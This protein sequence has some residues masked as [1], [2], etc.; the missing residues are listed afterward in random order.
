MSECGFRMCFSL[1]DPPRLAEML[2][3]D[4]YSTSDE[5]DE[6]DYDDDDDD[7]DDD[8]YD[9]DDDDEERDE[10][11]DDDEDDEDDDDD[12]EKEL[13]TEQLLDGAG[14]YYSGKPILNFAALLWLGLEYY[15]YN[16][17]DENI[18]NE[19]NENGNG[20]GNTENKK[21]ESSSS[22]STSMMNDLTPEDLLDRVGNYAS[23]PEAI[24]ATIALFMLWK[25]SKLSS[26]SSLSPSSF[27]NYK[28]IGCDPFMKGI[29]PDVHVQIASFL[30]PR[31]VVTLSCVSK[32]Y[33]TITDESNNTTSVAIWK[34]LWNRD[35]SWIVYQWTI[36]KQA[37]LRSNCTQWSYSKDFYFLFGQSYLD[38]VIAGHNTLTNCLVGIHSNIY[39]IT[40]FLFSHPGT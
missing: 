22:S 26:S 33:H 37:F 36:G 6:D 25:K 16:E 23:P 27:R 39:D 5:D 38:Y 9:E 10:E 17:N 13:M 24:M 20:N 7:S 15:D 28:N 1:I 4:V 18:N 32:A 31:D 29:P 8:D 11:D 3:V 30:H 19:N 14:M 34:T 40:P 2:D 35:Y 12:E 21:E